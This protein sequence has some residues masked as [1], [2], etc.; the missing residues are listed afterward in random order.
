VHVIIGLVLAIVGVL[1]V[2]FR[3]KIGPPA[4]VGGP[5]LGTPAYG[6]WKKYSQVLGVAIGCFLVVA[7]LLYAVGVIG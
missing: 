1:A 4:H 3:S 2:V 5:D 7:G 6:A